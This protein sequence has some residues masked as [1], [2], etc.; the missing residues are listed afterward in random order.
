MDYLFYLFHRK[1]VFKFNSDYVVIVTENEQSNNPIQYVLKFKS[2][3]QYMPNPTV[4][5]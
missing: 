2:D 1:D 3:E 5:Y 4:S